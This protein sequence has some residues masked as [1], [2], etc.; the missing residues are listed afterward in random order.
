MGV[1]FWCARFVSE[2]LRLV[3]L[4]D[5]DTVIVTKCLLVLQPAIGSNVDSC[6]WEWAPEHV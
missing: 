1:V 5:L 2:L 3:V 6:G 4:A